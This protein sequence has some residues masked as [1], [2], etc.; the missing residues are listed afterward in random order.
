M[1][2]VGEEPRRENERRKKAEDARE[3]AW[4]ISTVEDGNVPVVTWRENGIIL[5]AQDLDLPFRFLKSETLL[6][7][8]GAANYE[9]RTKRETRGRSA[10]TSVRVMK[11][12]SVRVGASR[13]T[14][15][16]SDVITFRGTGM[17]AV[18]T[19]HVYFKGDERSVRIPHGKIVSVDTTRLDGRPTVELVRDRAS[20]HP[21]FFS[22]NDRETA[23]FVSELIAAIP[24]IA[25]N[26]SSER[27]KY[28]AGYPAVDQIGDGL[29]AED[30]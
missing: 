9:Q 19:K 1:T 6:W 25:D 17:L 12:V 3:K 18:T 24:A 11:G 4:I 28:E 16:E 23:E 30:Q 14:P 22:V 2:Q 13:G 5:H 26:S 20:G 21:E 7:V 15:V 27:V 29:F 8:I 10:G